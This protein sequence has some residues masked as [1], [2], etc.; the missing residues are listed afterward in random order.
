VCDVAG[1]RVSLESLETGIEI[2]T[3]TETVNVNVIVT[4]TVTVDSMDGMEGLKRM[5]RLLEETVS[6]WASLAEMIE[7]VLGI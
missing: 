3:A 2:V 6:E 1:T 7:E 5:D 4:V